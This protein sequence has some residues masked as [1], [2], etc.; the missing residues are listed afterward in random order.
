M[1]IREGPYLFRDSLKQVFRFFICILK[2]IVTTEFSTHMNTLK[3]SEQD[4]KVLFKDEGSH[5]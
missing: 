3:C 2:L 5:A 4:N 1:F